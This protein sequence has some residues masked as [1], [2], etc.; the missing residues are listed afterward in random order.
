[1]RSKDSATF[2][3]RFEQSSSELITAL[4]GGDGA[5]QILDDVI[6]EAHNRLPLAPSPP[7]P[8]PALTPARARALAKSTLTP[9]ELVC[10]IRDQLS[11]LEATTE[12]QALL[13]VLITPA[14]LLRPELNF[15]LDPHTNKYT[16][17]CPLCTPPRDNNVAPTTFKIAL[18]LNRANLFKHAHNMHFNKSLLPSTQASASP[19]SDSN[20]STTTATPASTPKRKRV[21][22]P[23]APTPS[24][25]S[26]PSALA[27]RASTSTGSLLHL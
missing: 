2:S 6:A 10:W 27:T 9:A 7:T 8:A 21:T 14:G 18:P 19:S 3:I 16:W 25:P 13:A 12:A 15:Q 5:A 24:L 11:T 20:S 1:M 26:S 23:V 22:H 17:R 4:G